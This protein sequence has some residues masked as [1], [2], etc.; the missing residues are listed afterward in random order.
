MWSFAS[1]CSAVSEKKTF[2]VINFQSNMAAVP[3]ALLHHK[4]KVSLEWGSGSCLLS[5]M[6]IRQGAFFYPR[7]PPNHVT[8]DIIIFTIYAG[9]RNDSCQVLL[10]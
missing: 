4:F 8:C 9:M 2:K 1:I 6:L 5:F 7:W 10:G 3:S